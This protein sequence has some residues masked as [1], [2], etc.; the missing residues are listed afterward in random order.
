[1]HD[2]RI[3]LEVQRPICLLHHVLVVHRHA[4]REVDLNI[5]LVVGGVEIPGVHREDQVFFVVDGAAQEGVIAYEVGVCAL[6]GLVRT[7]GS[8]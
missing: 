3:I 6:E 5:P 7:L 2:L 8:M 1:V 4:G